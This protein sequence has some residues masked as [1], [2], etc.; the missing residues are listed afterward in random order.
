MRKYAPKSDDSRKYHLPTPIGGRILI[1]ILFVFLAFVNASCMRHPVVIGFAGPLTGKYYYLG[2]QAR[3]GVSMAI[4]E[5]N[6]SGGIDGM[7]VKLEVENTLGSP[8]GAKRAF[9][10]LIGKGIRIIIGPMLSQPAIAIMPVIEK[11]NV[12]VISPTVSTSRLSKRK[13]N[14]FRIIPDSSCK[15][16]ALGLFALHTRGVKKICIVQDTSNLEYTSDFIKHFLKPYDSAG[17][18]PICLVPFRTYKGIPLINQ[19]IEDLLRF[20]PEGVV[21]AASTIDAAIIAR[22]LWDKNSHVI[23]FAA[24]WAKSY[25]FIANVGTPIYEIYFEDIAPGNPSERLKTFKEKY[26]NTYG[27]I[28]SVGAIQ[29]YDT[30]MLLAY[31]M[32]KAG[33]NIIDIKHQLTRIKK[34]PGLYSSISVNAYGDA[35]R[36]SFIHTIK[37]GSFITVKKIEQCM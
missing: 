33:T 7:E 26:F 15:A 30:A 17:I 9:E 21:V 22:K 35:I 4:S 18:N 10:R 12:V 5:I 20:E 23:I 32:E 16:R 25:N 29:G 13:D 27:R 8:E 34:F 3:N 14:F 31:V 28:A 11:L 24:N 1:F 19:Q 36:P 37:E 2:V 6:R